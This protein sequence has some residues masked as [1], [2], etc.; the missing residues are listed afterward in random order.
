MLEEIYDFDDAL[1]E[2]EYYDALLYLLGDAYPDLSLEELENMLEDILDVLPDHLA[3]SVLN[4]VGTIGKKIGSGALTFAANNPGLVK[5]ALT[6]AGTIVGGPVGGK[7]AGGLGNLVTQAA[8]NKAM[9]QTA[10]MLGMMQNPQAQAAVARATLG[11]GN[12]TAPLS[13]NGNTV[14]VPVAIYLRAITSSAQAA[15]MELEKNSVIPPIQY[16]EAIPYAEDVEMQAEWLADQL[17]AEEEET[18]ADYD[19]DHFL[20]SRLE[21]RR[22]GAKIAKYSTY[23]GEQVAKG[24][25]SKKRR[26]ICIYGPDKRNLAPVKFR[27]DIKNTNSVYNMRDTFF[28]IHLLA[29][30]ESGRQEMILLKG[31]KSNFKYIDFIEIP[32]ESSRTA[33]I[34]IDLDALRAASDFFRENSDQRRKLLLK[35]E[36]NWSEGPLDKEYYIDTVWYVFYLMNPIEIVISD[37]NV[38]IQSVNNVIRADN[39]IKL[40]G[41]NRSNTPVEINRTITTG[42]TRTISQQLQ[43]SQRQSTTFSIS[44]TESEVRTQTNSDE[45]SLG[46]KIDEILSAG[47]KS[48]SSNSVQTSQSTTIYAALTQEISTAYL[49]SDALASSLS[50]SHTEKIIIN[51]PT[52]GKTVN[53]YYVYPKFKPIEVDIIDYTSVNNYGFITYRK[54]YSKQIMWVYDGP[55]FLNIEE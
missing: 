46:L 19:Q 37:K 5:G 40:I 38:D 15:L 39:L 30:L 29:E 43:T 52:T 47:F 1:T 31:Q 18:F 4:T 44:D 8:Q 42:I 26:Y 51:P 35:I 45:F 34:E 54:V 22:S 6:T 20:Q 49:N 11:V 12:G 50:Q 9:P 13:V 28:K 36:F 3:E 17:H 48:S 55:G 7:I 33:H 41:E 24:D 10:K 27:F 16:S 23:D 53:K 21:E 2:D 25:N 14:Q 32:D